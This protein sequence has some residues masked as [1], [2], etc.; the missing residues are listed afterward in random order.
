VTSKRKLMKIEPVYTPAFDRQMCRLGT[1]CWSVA[2]L[3]QL[4]IG[5][6]V[7][8]IPLAHMEMYSTYEKMTLRQMCGHITSVNNADMSKP[9]ILD[10]DGC[11]MDGR[12]RLMRA[13][14]NGDDTIKAVRFAVNPTPC[15]VREEGS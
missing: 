8:E 6:E 13:I 5:F 2:R 3:A 7:M 10:E 1:H 12:H 14:I 4:S 11:I 15:E 9:I